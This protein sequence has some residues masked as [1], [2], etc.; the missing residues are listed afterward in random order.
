MNSIHLLGADD[1]RAASH[2]MVSAA[3]TI[4]S[5]VSY[6]ADILQRRQQWEEEFLQRLEQVLEK[7]NGKV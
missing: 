1:V 6:L 4:S 5:S 7:A 3:Q 2:T